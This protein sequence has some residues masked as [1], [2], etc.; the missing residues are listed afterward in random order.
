MDQALLGVPS[1]GTRGSGQ[2][3]MPRKFHLD[4]RKKLFPVKVAQVAHRS[5]GCPISGSV[6]G[7]VGQGLE[8]LGL[9]E[10]VP[11]MAGVWNKMIFKV[12]DLPRPYT[13]RKLIPKLV[14]K[15]YSVPVSGGHRSSTSV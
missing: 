3:L 8:E 10:G 4:I 11:A 15:D 13:L 7:Q 6:Q 12:S 9:V 5:C 1:D 14:G 2:K